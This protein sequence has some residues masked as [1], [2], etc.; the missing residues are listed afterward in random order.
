MIKFFKG[1]PERDDKRSKVYFHQ[2]TNADKKGRHLWKVG[3]TNDQPRVRRD[4]YL[5]KHPNMVWLANIRT[6]WYPINEDGDLM[7]RVR[8][9]ASLKQNLSPYKTKRNKYSTNP[10]EMYR[11]TPRQILGAIKRALTEHRRGRNS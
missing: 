9:D 5:R 11:G 4:D 10:T 2:H 3:V 1:D 6:R 7:D 8:F